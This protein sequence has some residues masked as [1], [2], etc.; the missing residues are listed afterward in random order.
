MIIK[1]SSKHQITLPKAIAEAFQLKKGDVFE[2]EIKGN[3]I[4]MIPKEMILEDKYPQRDLKGAE[5]AL[6]KGVPEEEISF[7]SGAE[8]TKFF[9]KR[10]KK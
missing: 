6:S 4:I 9:K 2:I 3:K 7:K 10:V 8:M 5:E 1:L